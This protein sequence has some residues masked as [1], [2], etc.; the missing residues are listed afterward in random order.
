MRIDLDG[1]SVL[2][3]QLSLLGNAMYTN[4]MPQPRQREDGR[5]G[6]HVGALPATS[7]LGVQGGPGAVRILIYGAGEK[8]LAKKFRKCECKASI[9]LCENPIL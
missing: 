5:P 7:V 6:E 2:G 1:K 8:L 4:S 9:F 3:Q